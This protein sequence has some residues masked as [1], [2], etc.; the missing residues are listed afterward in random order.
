LWRG[1]RRQAVFGHLIRDQ[2]AKVTENNAAAAG[3]IANSRRI[4]I[5]TP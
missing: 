4:L 3:V 5:L 1:N 2:T